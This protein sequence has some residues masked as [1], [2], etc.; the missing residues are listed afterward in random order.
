MENC[1]Y[2]TM[3]DLQKQQFHVVLVYKQKLEVEPFF[4]RQKK[5]KE[6]KRS[7]KMDMT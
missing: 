1:P 7:H 6:E 3:F 4:P 2:L 5:K